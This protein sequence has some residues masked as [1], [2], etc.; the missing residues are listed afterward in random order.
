MSNQIE[1]TATVDSKRLNKANDSASGPCSANCPTIY[2]ASDWH[3]SLNALHHSASAPLPLNPFRP[4]NLRGR[5]SDRV[6]NHGV[7]LSQS[8]QLAV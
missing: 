3:S 6:I 2:S 8:L 7:N 5:R 4:P 1:F